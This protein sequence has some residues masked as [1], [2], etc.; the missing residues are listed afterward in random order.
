MFYYDAKIKYFVNK[1][2]IYFVNNKIKGEL[3]LSWLI[4]CACNYKFLYT[5][6]ETFFIVF[7]DIYMITNRHL[8]DQSSL[9]S[10]F[11]L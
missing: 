2:T 3:M 4:I 9:Y 5:K 7:M 1:G 6:I 11:T 10:V 8:Y